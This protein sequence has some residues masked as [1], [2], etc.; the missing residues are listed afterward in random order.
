[1]DASIE[2]NKMEKHQ[3]EA[4]KRFFVSLGFKT[5]EAHTDVALATG[6]T[7]VRTSRLTKQS[8]NG[9]LADGEEIQWP[10][11]YDVNIG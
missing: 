8:L 5:L 1:L 9:S 6:V 2:S 7:P 11:L 3:K 4:F 10:N